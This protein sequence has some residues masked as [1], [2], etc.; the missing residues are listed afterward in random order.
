MTLARA[1]LLASSLT[2]FACKTSDT[3]T[4]SDAV[5]VVEAPQATSEPETVAVDDAWGGRIFDRWYRELGQKFDAGKSG[6]PRGDGSLLGPDGSPRTAEGHGYRL[7]NFFGWDLRGAEGIYGPQYQNKAYVSKR[8]LLAEESSVEELVAWLRDG[9]DEI[10]AFGEVMDAKA[11][12]A[13]ATFIAKMQ[14]GELPR[15]DQVWS[16]SADAPKNYTLNPG[17]DVER[18]RKL[19]AQ[20][21]ASCHGEDGT[22]LAIDGT[23]SLGVFNRTKAYEGW[24]KVLNGHPGTPMHREL[25]IEGAE[26]GGPM[27]LDV[28]AALCDRKVFPALA[29]NDVADG[30]ARCGAYLK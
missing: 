25:P 27:I 23:L 17:A 30:D 8:N 5:P 10:P 28:V 15:A 4:P 3:A 21:C 13:T 1:A 2:L 9:D 11:L 7:K 14:R 19:Y 18:G 20:G 6:G 24:I 29:D 12:E 22:T 16:L 26:E